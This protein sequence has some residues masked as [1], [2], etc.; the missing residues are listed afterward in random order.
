MTPEL[1]LE[2]ALFW[3]ES[4][5]KRRSNDPEKE[6]ESR[7]SERWFEKAIQEEKNRPLAQR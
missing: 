2:K 7:L 4:S 5:D 1:A 3:R 6:I